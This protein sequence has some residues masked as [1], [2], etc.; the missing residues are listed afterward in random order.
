MKPRG[1][2]YQFR[3][4]VPA[5]LGEYEGKKEIRYSLNTT[6]K[7]EAK[8]RARE[9]YLK[10]EENF[11]RI[12][13][14][15]GVSELSEELIE[16]LV[17]RWTVSILAEDE[18]YRIDGS[19]RT[20]IDENTRELQELEA[21][22]RKS[23][24]HGEFLLVERRADE[25]LHES[26]I[27]LDKKSES[28]R[29]LC[30]RILKAS[31]GLMTSLR[32]RNRGDVVDTPR[33]P[34]AHT[35][36]P[37]ANHKGTAVTLATVIERWAKENTP[38]ERTLLEWRRIVREFTEVSEGVALHQL[39]RAHVVAYKDSLVNAG[40]APA[41]T[42]KKVMAVNTLLRWAKNNELVADNVAQGVTVKH[43]KRAKSDRLPYS[44]EDLR[45]IFSSPIYTRGDRPRGG[46]GEAAYWLPLL[47]AHTG[48]RREEL[49]QLLTSDVRTAEGI[50]YLAITDEDGDKE[51]KTDPRR[52]PV[53][54]LLEQLGF[55]DYVTQQ[56]AARRERLFH[57]LLPDAFGRLSEAWGKWFG[58]YS[59]KVIGITDKRKVFHSFRHSF[60]SA[61]RRAGIEEEIH[62]ALTGHAG[63]SVGRNYGDYPLPALAN[64]MKKLRYEGILGTT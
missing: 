47:A 27:K 20:I 38:R 43:G 62:E 53:H 56:R 18:G 1:R 24:A 8:R 26:G 52:V 21:A 22:Y 32:A 11:D 55:L 34:A 15:R 42:W 49:C 3:R 45:R 6:D 37:Q 31:I 48:A 29:R 59:R 12:R 58:N 2:V 4:R 23:L 5:D 41:T 33:A 13:A 63:G 36:T 19:M 16:N 10:W 25:V 51:I 17:T 60:K 28:Y 61:C 64:A 50:N 54:P 9:E 44:E 40:K 14:G 35:A 39:T 30:F 57:L 46:K 7:L